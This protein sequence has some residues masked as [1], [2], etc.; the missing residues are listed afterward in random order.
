M[1]RASSWILAI[2]ILLALALPCIP[3]AQAEEIHMGEFYGSSENRYNPG[4]VRIWSFTPSNSGE[5]ILDNYNGL[6]SI[7]L[8]GQSPLSYSEGINTGYYKVYHLIGGS[9]YT[10]R[11]TWN[12]SEQY[13]AAFAIYEK[14]P[15]EYLTMYNTQMTL[16][17]GDSNCVSVEYAPSYYSSSAIVWSCSDTSIVNIDGS[18]GIQGSVKGMRVGTA[19][20]TASLGGKQASCTIDVVK[21]QGEWDN[22]PLWSSSQVSVSGITQYRVEPASSGWYVTYLSGGSGYVEMRQTNWVTELPQKNAH[23]YN[24][25]YEL[26]YLQAGETYVATVV[27]QGGSVTAVLQMAQ[28]AKKVTLYG[29]NRTDGTQIVGAVGGQQPLY[30]EADPLYAYALE[31]DYFVYS[32]SDPS[33]AR[34]EKPSNPYDPSREVLLVG[35][36]TCTIT[37]K[38]GNAVAKC[39]VTVAAQYE[40]KVGQTTTLKLSGEAYGV[41]GVFKPEKSGNYRFVMTGAGGTATIEG[42]DIGTYVH[43]NGSMSGYLEAGKTYLV[44]LSFG[45]S[46]HTVKVEYLDQTEPEKGD[47]IE[48]TEPSATTQTTP[49]STNATTP[50]TQPDNTQPATG[51]AAETTV[52]ATE[53][54][55]TVVEV[56]D[57]Q[58]AL[59][60]QQLEQLAAEGS[61]LELRQEDLTVQLDAAALTT[62][63]DASSGDVRLVASMLTLDAL[64]DAQQ[65][66]V[67]EKFAGAVEISLCSGD[68]NIHQLGGKARVRIPFTPETGSGQDYRVYW[69]SE[70]GQLE[71]MATEYK[72]GELCFTTE[73]FSTFVILHEP[74]ESSVLVPVLIAL[75]A[76]V[77]IGGI[78]VLILLRKKNK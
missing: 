66:A 59:A 78:T 51:E 69:L 14:K 53:P 32:S 44:H 13:M 4:D 37:V 16:G 1:K 76:L 33:V 68:V 11:A 42:T 39:Q 52:P 31:P 2:T 65:A 26:Y 43:G 54:P 58:Q 24:G 18:A 75:A 71:P 8:D 22:Y 6:S 55:V 19:T 41:T 64:T 7:T 47:G 73:H 25:N 46:D 9:T 62:A 63:L 35:P 12:G 3:V 27:P 56:T 70:D 29:P 77:V 40:F 5:Y 36:G 50:G 21:P 45:G 67:A 72:N 17:K 74:A 60:R 48:T 38:V 15:L 49:D 61:T 30:A 57:P 20:V 23:L 34:L 28:S 10:I